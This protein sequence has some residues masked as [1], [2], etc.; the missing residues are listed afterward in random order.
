MLTP[1]GV[2][3]GLLVGVVEAPMKAD[4][5]IVRKPVEELGIAARYGLVEQA[6]TVEIA[7]DE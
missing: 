3:E 2:E 5:T 4:E 7:A 1:F 6:G